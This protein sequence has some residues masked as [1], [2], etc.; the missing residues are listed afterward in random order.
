M[1]VLS[2]T[3]ELYSMDKN[4]LY[5]GNKTNEIS[6]PLGGI[7]SG[8]IG[9]AGNGRLI[10]WEI[11]N[12]P[13]KNSFNGFSFFAIKA[14]HQGQ[15]RLAKVLNGDIH[16]P[17]SGSGKGKF[18]GF[19][20]GVERETLAGLPH[21]K[22]TTFKGEFPVAEVN[23]EDDENILDVKLTAFNPFIPL[24]DK[25]SSIP[26]A[27]LTYEV[28]NRSEEELDISLVGNLT[29]PF[30]KG[31][32]NQ[33]TD[34][35]NFHGIKLHSDHYAEDD[36]KFGDL[37]L[38]S[39]GND[40]SYQSYWYRGGWFDNLT[41]F[42]KDFKAPGRF[43][44]RNY[45]IK[46]EAHAVATYNRLDVCLLSSHKTLEPGEKAQFRFMIS[47]NIPNYVNS[48]NPGEDDSCQP[49]S[50]KNY[51]ATLFEDSTKSAEYVWSHYERLYKETNEFKESLFNSTL[52]D[53]VLDAISSNLSILKSPTCARL[54]DG[55][56]Y[57]FEGC[58]AQEGCCEGSCTH[59]WN[60]EQV[61]PFLFPSLARSMRNA[62]YKSTQF[63]NGK[64]T[65]R[66][67]L[68][69]DRTLTDVSACAGPERA[70]A[71]GQMGGI[72]KVYREWIISGDTDWLKSIWP[73]VKKAL[74]FAWDPTNTD[75]WD[76]DGDGVMEGIQHHTLDVEIYGPN[77]YITGLYHGAL[78]AAFRMAEALGDEAG[79][80]YYDLYQKGRKWV[81]ENLFNGE[82]F[83]QLIDLKDER[84]PIDAELEE[85]KYQIGEGC[86]IDQV[87]GQWHA[88]IV[89]LGYIFDETKVKKSVESIYKYNFI[90]SM[91]DYAN[92][93]RMYAVNDE[94][95][96]MICTWPKDNSPKVP[97]PYA[98]E[99][100]NGFEYQAACHM[101]YEGYLQ[102]GLRSVKAIRDRY[103]G[104]RRNPWNEFECGSNYARSMASYSLLVALSG[105]EYDMVQGHIGFNPR[106]NQEQFRTFW[107]LNNG[108]GEFEHQDGQLRLSVKSGD[109]NLCSFRS[110]L[111]KGQKII[112]VRVGEQRVPFI[113]EDSNLLFESTVQLHSEQA[114]VI[115]TKQ[116]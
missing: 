22:R 66:M 40:I 14:E 93:C 82:Y 115:I 69:M 38:S 87:I 21:F 94:Q 50:W 2:M 80:K 63:D 112:E 42:W 103:D 62:D 20:F 79:S 9:L 15:I 27:I 30:S 35:G 32:I 72:I 73:K 110:E 24:N 114:L 12:T 4:F 41:L 31:A 48:W 3:T 67:M 81:D 7:G 29:N 11:F 52:P 10:D 96:L 78:L 5:T 101:I 113:R 56:L 86:H 54:T 71:D 26:V 28:V 13:N 60:Y 85:I 55:T 116:E 105:F 37:T 88:H 8:C 45:N 17:Y 16:A 84:F 106:I 44:E 46:R 100:M 77:T 90:E 1:E 89:G 104:E 98:D 99:C 51:Y 43:K 39:D 91:R 102:E 76:K 108:W 33:Y 47:W 83:H 74:E 57:G 70:A 34:F 65:F 92:A 75:W 36:P 59:V 6:F 111:L 95:G 64:M 68:P 18:N 25:D 58:H 23:F 97:I 19:G 49:P 53:Y 109:L 107:S 61:T